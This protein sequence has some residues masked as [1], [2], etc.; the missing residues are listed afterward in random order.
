MV[1]PEVSINEGHVAFFPFCWQTGDVMA[2]FG[3]EEEQHS[4][5]KVETPDWTRSL[6][7]DGR[8]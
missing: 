1:L 3:Q 2:A 5:M 4:L 7:L 6:L 8:L